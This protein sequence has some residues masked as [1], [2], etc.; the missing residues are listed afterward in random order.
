MEVISCNCCDPIPALVFHYGKKKLRSM[1]WR[2]RAEM[3]RRRKQKCSSF[4]YDPFSYSLNFDNGDCGAFSWAS[5][6]SSRSMGYVQA[7]ECTC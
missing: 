4:H 3:R 2:V 7:S 1:F 6:Q 5:L